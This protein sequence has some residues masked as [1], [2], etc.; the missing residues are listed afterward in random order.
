MKPCVV[1]QE[2][3]KNISGIEKVFLT[4]LKPEDKKENMV[5]YDHYNENNDKKLLL[6][7]NQQ[8]KIKTSL[9]WKSS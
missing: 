5:K 1:K 6:M 9:T 4:R 8:K 2:L 7:T 3:L